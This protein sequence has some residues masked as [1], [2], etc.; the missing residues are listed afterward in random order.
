M[1]K[2]FE[3]LLRYVILAESTPF[4]YDTEG[5]VKT[6]LMST[7]DI[8]IC[9]FLAKLMAD[10]LSTYNTIGPVN[11]KSMWEKYIYDSK[12]MGNFDNY[13]DCSFLC[14]NVEKDNACDL[15]TI[16]NGICY[17]GKA[18]HT[19]GEVELELADATIYITN[20]EK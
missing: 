13:L 15:F 5:L 2:A 19:A 11:S 3:G 6:E 1:S 12:T 17:F 18:S 20:G 16:E 9:L 8:N 10:F 7:V 14:K 4:S